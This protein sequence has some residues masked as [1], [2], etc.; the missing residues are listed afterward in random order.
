MK[1]L[2]TYL[3][4]LGFWP[5]FIGFAVFANIL[6]LISLYLNYKNNTKN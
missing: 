2:F 4:S 6:F 1:E 3:D 5:V